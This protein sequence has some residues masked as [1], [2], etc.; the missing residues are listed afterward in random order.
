MSIFARDAT[1]RATYA[2]VRCPSVRHVH[3]LYR[4]DYI[5]S[6][7]FHPPVAPTILDFRTNRYGNLRTGIP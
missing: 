1:Y 7:F 3:V 6:N 4:N 2:V 5:P